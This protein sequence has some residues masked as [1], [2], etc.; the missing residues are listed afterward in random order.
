MAVCGLY[1]G[2]SAIPSF[3]GIVGDCKFSL[4]SQPTANLATFGE[5]HNLL[6]KIKETFSHGPH[7]S[8]LDGVPQ[9]DPLGT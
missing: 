2:R 3:M 1:K 5:L 7:L 8:H 9:P 6:G 4:L